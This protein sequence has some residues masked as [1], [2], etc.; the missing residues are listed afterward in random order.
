KLRARNEVFLRDDGRSRAVVD[1][2]GGGL[3]RLDA[4]EVT[5]LGHPGRAFLPLLDGRFLPAPSASL[6]SPGILPRTLRSRCPLRRV[7]D[8]RTA[9]ESQRESD[10]CKLPRQPHQTSG[11]K[12][13]VTSVSR[14][15]PSAEASAR[16]RNGCAKAEH[17]AYN[18]G[19]RQAGSFDLARV[20]P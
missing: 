18:A 6:A 5:K 19:L 11:M 4:A 1:D 8:Q 15:N 13:V 7:G 17:P 16:A 10:Q 20:A 12:R 14:V 9:C 3:R 2:A